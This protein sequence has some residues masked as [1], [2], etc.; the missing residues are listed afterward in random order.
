MSRL[1]L[2]IRR[3]EINLGI[4]TVYEEIL[5]DCRDDHPCAKKEWML[6]SEGNDVNI[7]LA[8]LTL[9]KLCLPDVMQILSYKNMAT[10]AIHLHSGAR[11]FWTLC[12]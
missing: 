11:V 3:K 4:L 8:N 12:N 7:I 10:L 5:S 2:A 9:L 1:R 6:S